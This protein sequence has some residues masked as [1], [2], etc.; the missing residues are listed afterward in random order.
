MTET[1]LYHIL[2]FTP[3]LD[4]AEVVSRIVRLTASF[5]TAH[6]GYSKAC[7]KVLENC[8][9]DDCTHCMAAVSAT[10]SAPDARVWEVWDDEKVIGIVYLTD[11][12]HGYDATAHYVFFDGKL[13]DKTEII[14]D[15]IDWLFTEHLEANWLALRRLSIAV[16]TV[17]FALAQHAFK[18]LGFGGDFRYESRG[19]SLPVEGV[20]RSA[21]VWRGAPCDLL[22]MGKVNPANVL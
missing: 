19:K 15:M 10:L 14:L 11:I 22:L 2:P 16:P 4:R 9:C 6:S 18:H 5:E 1:S 12:L 8:L 7:D 13:R 20:R 17:A 3:T 21:I